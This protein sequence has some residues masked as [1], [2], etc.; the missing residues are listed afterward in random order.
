[1][2]A[3]SFSGETSQGPFWKQILEERKTQTCREPRVHPIKEGD[4]LTLYW[5]QRTPKHLKPIHLIGTARC[6]KVERKRYKEFAFDDEFARRDGFKDSRELRIFFGD[7]RVYGGQEYD[8]IHF[9]METKETPREI[10]LDSW[11]KKG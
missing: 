7:P 11:L 9:K 6:L 4:D 5:K 2:P 10:G 1:M 3:I 8:V